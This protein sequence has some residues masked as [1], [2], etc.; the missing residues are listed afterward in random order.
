MFVRINFWRVKKL[1]V[2]SYHDDNISISYNCG[3]SFDRG[4]VPYRRASGFALRTAPIFLERWSSI[5][6]YTQLLLSGHNLR[7]SFAFRKQ[8][9]N[10]KGVSFLFWTVYFSIWCITCLLQILD[11]VLIFFHVSEILFYIMNL[12]KYVS[13]NRGELQMTHSLT[14]M[15]VME[16]ILI[17]H[18]ESSAM[19]RTL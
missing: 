19:V 5:F 1:F 9:M 15:R 10:S 17:L 2:G 13:F 7:M 3:C 11:A 4:H 12:I 6:V 16:W 18:R 14:T 8:Y